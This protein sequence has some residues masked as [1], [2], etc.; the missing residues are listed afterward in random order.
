MIRFC[1]SI[2]KLPGLRIDN[3]SNIN[4]INNNEGSGVPHQFFLSNTCNDHMKG[5]KDIG[6]IVTSNPA[7]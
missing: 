3:F 2:P 7:E 6:P 4:S 1:G 5:L